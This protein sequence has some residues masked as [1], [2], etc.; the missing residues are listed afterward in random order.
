MSG[1]RIFADSNDMIAIFFSLLNPAW[2]SPLIHP[3]IH[4]SI[5]PGIHSFIRASIH[6]FIHSFVVPIS[7]KSKKKQTNIGRKIRWNPMESDGIGVS[8]R[9][10]TP[11]A[12]APLRLRMARMHP[13]DG[14]Q[15]F[16]RNRPGKKLKPKLNGTGVDETAVVTY[17]SSS[18]N[19]FLI[20]LPV[21]LEVDPRGKLWWHLYL[22]FLM[23]FYSWRGG[24]GA[25][26][27]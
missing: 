9:E 22:W 4:S 23:T 12:M 10:R 20:Y 17:I 18:D 6:T 13:S 2:N 7:S 5:D 19:N 16:G 11:D 21:D 26:H 14:R 3:F 15:C 25:F 1:T 27:S 24:A 8:P